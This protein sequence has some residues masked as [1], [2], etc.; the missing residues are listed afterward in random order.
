MADRI[1]WEVFDRYWD[2][3]FSLAGGPEAK[4]GRLVSGLLMLK[5]M[6][7]L[8]DERLMEAWLSNPYYQYFCGETQFH[9]SGRCLNLA[10]ITP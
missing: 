8:S 9:P 2:Q 5:H 7:A 6:E 3:Q 4:P 10:W 1:E